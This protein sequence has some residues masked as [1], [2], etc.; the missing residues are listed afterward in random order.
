MR[1]HS[2]PMNL[3]AQIEKKQRNMIR[4]LV[5]ISHYKT[6]A[7]V[8]LQLKYMFYLFHKR[9]KCMSLIPYFCYLRFIQLWMCWEL[10]TCTL[11]DS[12]LKNGET[13]TVLIVLVI[14]VTSKHIVYYLLRRT[15]VMKWLFCSRFPG[16]LIWIKD[17]PIPLPR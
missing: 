6:G 2:A 11:F 9:N 12:P 4:L 15:K 14:A 17:V 3:S 10:L 1:S 8:G 7:Y 16:S 5:K 13:I